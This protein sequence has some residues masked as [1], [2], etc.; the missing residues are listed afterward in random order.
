MSTSRYF[1]NFPTINQGYLSAGTSRQ[2]D[3]FTFND[4]VSPNRDAMRSNVIITQNVDKYIFENPISTANFNIVKVSID[5][6]N[7]LNDV[8]D[9]LFLD[10]LQGH[11][12][13]NMS[14]SY[15]T[16]IS[17][18]KTF[19]R[20]FPV[21]NNLLNIRF[22]NEKV[23]DIRLDHE[24]SLSKFTQF[25]PPSELNS[26]VDYSEMANLT[27]NANN[28][29]D[30]VS[31]NNFQNSKIINRFGFFNNNIIN[32]QL[33]APVEILENTSNTYIE[34]FGKSDSILDEFEF[35]I[36]GD[37]EFSTSGRLSNDIQIF[38]TSNGVISVSQYKS[39]DTITL[40]QINK[41]NISIIQ[42]GTGKLMNYI[43]K[44][45][46]SGSVPQYYINTIEEGILKQV[47]MSGVTSFQNGYVEIKI[48]DNA[49]NSKTIWTAG[50]RDGTINQKW[51]P[52][53]LIPSDH[54]VYATV[55]EV[56]TT[57]PLT[58]DRLDLNMKLL[59]YETRPINSV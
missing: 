3:N 55:S 37:A 58:F 12:P 40:P 42:N 53:I 32:N 23:G 29:Y 50:I 22:R 38:G 45:F 43:P 41:G 25:N 49:S 36:S 47:N 27:R 6:N 21:K 15:T 17:T 44:G 52:D 13:E 10:V 14:V 24:I 35:T 19:Y 2:G 16:P 59:V 11:N 4:V 7:N 54:T 9:T 34:V 1:S 31:R 56:D 39:I 20:N 33:I 48:M 57:D 30:D 28:F 8:N 18:F 5:T 46:G 26:Q 51:K